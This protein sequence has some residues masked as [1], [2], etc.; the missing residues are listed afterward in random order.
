MTPDQQKVI[1]YYKSEMPSLGHDDNKGIIIPLT[2]EQMEQDITK[3]NHAII[4]S[5][6]EAAIAIGPTPTVKHYLEMAL[7]AQKL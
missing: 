4:T 7:G 6:I 2:P 3:T 5:Y 1:D